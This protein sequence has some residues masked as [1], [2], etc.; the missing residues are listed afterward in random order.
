MTGVYRRKALDI[1]DEI[2]N[3]GVTLEEIAVGGVAVGGVLRALSA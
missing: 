1:R 3:L 2:P